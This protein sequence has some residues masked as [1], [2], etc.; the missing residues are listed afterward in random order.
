MADDL[1]FPGG[2]TSRGRDGAPGNAPSDMSASELA[3]ALRDN[4]ALASDPAFMARLLEAT[5]GVSASS[6]PPRTPSTPI[7]QPPP[8]SPFGASGR[9]A[10][11]SLPGAAPLPPPGRRSPGGSGLPGAAPLATSGGRSSDRPD[12]S[13]FPPLPPRDPLVGNPFSSSPR[14]VPEK[15]APPRP[16]VPGSSAVFP[17]ASPSVPPLP[18]TEKSAGKKTSETFASNFSNVAPT[19]SDSVKRD[20]LESLAALAGLANRDDSE[21]S[22]KSPA[23]LPSA[24]G[25]RDANETPDAFLE[26][27]AKRN[28]PPTESSAAEEAQILREQSKLKRAANDA[29]MWLASLF[30]HVVLLII[31]AMLVVNVQLKDMFQVVSEPGFGD[32]VVLDDVFDPDSAMQTV[33]DANVDADVPEIDSEVVSDAPDASSFHEETAAPLSMTETTLALDSAP[34]GA[35]DNLMGSLMGDDLSGR[36]ENKAAALA[37]GGGTEGSEKSVALALAWIAEHQLPDGSWSFNMADCPSC[38]GECRNSG[39]N[40]SRTAATSLGILPFLA[41][42]NTP[43]RG[44][45]KRVVAKG[46]G[47]LLDQ[48]KSSENGVSFHDPSGTM[49]SHGLA[50]IA[51]CETFAMLNSKERAKYR[52]L[53]YVT[54]AAVHFIE[55]A[56]ASD[57]GWRY[58]P[59]QAGDTSVTGWQLMALRAAMLAGLPVAQ[60]SWIDARSFLR[61]VV[62]FE[63]GTRYNYVRGA[64]ETNAT[65]AIGLL[66]RLY[67]DWRIDNPSLIR[68]A[69]RLAAGARNL[70]NPYYNYYAAQLLYNLGGR[71]W[72]DWNRDMRERL[73]AAQCAN[74]HERGSWYPSRPDPNGHCE[75][76]GRL[77]VTSLNCMVLEVYYRHMPLY[78]K[79]EL[80]GEL[81]MENVGGKG[82]GKATDAEKTSAK[83]DDESSDDDPDEDF[84]I[85]DF[86]DEDE[87]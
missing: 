55:Y 7:P 15:N 18:A 38:R 1:H 26:L 44:K 64:Q 13:L 58:S 83:D 32:E 5:R 52:K 30:F 39:T 10:R 43:T 85:E 65:D 12:A 81:T 11:P 19:A 16:A 35:T 84:P 73:I 4:P 37:A 77:Y 14:G 24:F 3:K 49:Y 86:S 60:D 21:E 42:G 41:A 76:G 8:K 71:V 17:S 68:G 36:G 53:E 59:K 22:R 31:L 87:E 20:S 6:A 80:S 56:Q 48:G 9:G 40:S 2:G 29:P 47:F 74:G 62:A 23:A 50:T 78:Q 61:D 33:D 63:D 54:N 27:L 79:A 69:K 57:G 67:I 51:I 75:E 34:V 82:R 72:N 25:A 28:L 46:L 45:Y 66:C 70:D